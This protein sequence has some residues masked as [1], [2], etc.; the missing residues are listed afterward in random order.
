MCS[1][2]IHPFLTS[3]LDGVGLSVS[4][5]VSFTP[6]G[7]SSECLLY[8]E[9]ERVIITGPLDIL[10]KAERPALQSHSQ[11]LLLKMEERKSR[12]K[13]NQGE[14]RKKQTDT[15]HE[16][17][18]TEINGPQ[19]RFLHGTLVLQSSVRLSPAYSTCKQNEFV[20]LTVLIMKNPVFWDISPFSFA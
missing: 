14:K 11:S 15:G 5:S 12:R 19:T 13:E 9:K 20:F 16:S 17:L 2:H 8:T 1:L 10:V 7:K 18:W 3:L 4:L 6:G